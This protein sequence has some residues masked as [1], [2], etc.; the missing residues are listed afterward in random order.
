MTSAID[1]EN[2]VYIDRLCRLLEDDLDFHDQDSGYAS[3][4]IHSFPA[5][6][7]PQL[8]R[9]FIQALTLPGETVLD[10]MMGS[11]TTV[12][13][14]FLLGRRGIG[15][16]I[17]PLAVMLARAKVSPISYHDAV[18]WTRKI[19]SNAKE[20]FLSR[21]RAL[22]D[23]MDRMWDEETRDFVNYWFCREVQLALTAL[24]VEINRI[25]DDS[26]RN[27]FR[28]ILSSII[29]TKSGGVSL[30]LDLAH[31]RPHRV[32]RAI[33]WN[34]CLL[35]IDIS[36]RSER[37]KLSKKIRS[38]FD[39]FE[40]KCIQNLKSMSENGL[41]SDQLSIGCL[42]EWE[43]MRIQ[44]DISTCDAKSLPLNNECVDVIITS[45]PYASHAIDYM[46]AHKFSLV[47]LGYAIRELSETRKR[48]IGGDALGG[49]GFES[50]PEQTSSIIDSLAR[51]DLRKGM[52]LRRYYSE[53]KAVLREMF[54]V[55]K[56]G[57]VAIVVVGG[58]KLRDQ[59]VEIDVCLSE[60]GESLG[61]SVP[62]IGVRRLDRNRRMMPVGNQ[63]DTKSQ[64]Q[65]RMH[66]EFV[67]GFYKPLIG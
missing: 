49:Y 61:F 7:P 48:Y 44:P 42:S 66:K 46:R 30:A 52:V 18:I 62:R 58:S 57:R 35:E 19:I 41:N 37:R 39:E 55:L 59:D 34:G 20:S 45:P 60:I 1:L 6:F 36:R 54:R 27:F 43:M 24:V 21:E 47:W 56:K 16:D 8:P 33:D 29:I 13:E 5:K 32:D 50:L 38:P 64:I 28:T 3:H 25:Q 10:P 17:D 63:I 11:G 51:K 40:K 67:I 15:F 22:Y 23:E 4:N 53:M 9:K 14:A 31:T 65:R 26:L 2:Q 12:L